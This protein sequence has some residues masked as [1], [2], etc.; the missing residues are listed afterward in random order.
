MWA[1]EQHID[2]FFADT[3]DVLNF[4]QY[5]AG[6]KRDIAAKAFHKGLENSSKS[7]QLELENKLS[8]IEQQ[9][10]GLKTNQQE[11][12]RA[13]TKNLDPPLSED[14]EFLK[15][16][17]TMAKLPAYLEKLRLIRQQGKAINAE[18]HLLKRQMTRIAR[19]YK[20]T[21][22][23]QETGEFLYQVVYPGGVHIRQ[24][25]AVGAPNTGEVLTHGQVVKVLERVRIW[26]DETIY[27]RL[28]EGKGWVFESKKAVDAL[29]RTTERVARAFAL[30]SPSCR[31]RLSTADTGSS[32]GVPEYDDLVMKI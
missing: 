31:S 11:L 6:L 12:L 3:E 17:R 18:V 32:G 2:A 13:L 7:I 25:P 15:V 20:G 4:E 22:P 26:G 1:F 5:Q 8:E 29:K 27:L 21:E 16:A 24:S 28:A 19:D 14:P 30:S 23:F 9:I 10:L